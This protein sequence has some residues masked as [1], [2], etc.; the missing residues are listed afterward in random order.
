[1]LH[2]VG[3]RDGK[4]FYR[5]RFVRT[6]GFAAEQ[7]ARRPLW[8][9]PRRDP[10]QSPSAT[11]AGARATLMKDASSTDVVVHPG[12]ALTQL[13]P[14]RRPLPPRPVTLAT[15]S[16]RRTGTAR[17]RPTGASRRTPRS[18]TRTGE[19]LFFNYGKEAPYMHYGVVDATDELVHYIDVPLPGPRLPHDMAFTENYAI[20]NDFPLFWDPELLGAGRPRARASTPTC[21]PASRVIPRRGGPSDIRWFEA[22]PTYVLHWINAYE[23]GDEIVLDGFFQGDPEPAD[24]GDGRQVRSARSGTSPSTGC[25]PACTAGGST[26]SPAQSREERLSRHASSSSA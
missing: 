2:V 5:N 19:L 4:A 12:I 14:V 17:S 16:A 18:T 26:S 6:D 1:M 20:L 15:R 22:D 10:S 11:T 23:D 25:R 8:A 9:G 24:A 7:E 3:F 21:R 13:L